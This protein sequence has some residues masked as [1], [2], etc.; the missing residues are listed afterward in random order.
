VIRPTGHRLTCDVAGCDSV[1]LS[2][3]D[4]YFVL[5]RDAE[6]RAG[7][8][9]GRKRNGDRAKTGGKDYCPQ[10]VPGGAR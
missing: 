1:M 8:H 5:I 3:G 4:N 7:W 6:D 10:H 9:L 2:D